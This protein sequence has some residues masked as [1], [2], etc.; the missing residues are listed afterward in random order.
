MYLAGSA[1]Q[2]VWTFYTILKFKWSENMIGNSL[3]AMIGARRRCWCKAGLVRIAI[4]K[5]GVARAIVLGL[6]CLH[7]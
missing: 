2:S 7:H 4:P 6:L 5:L 1:T 3:G